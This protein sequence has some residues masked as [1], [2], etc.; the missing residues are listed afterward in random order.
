MPGKWAKRRLRLAKGVVV[1]S[2]IPFLIHAYEYGPDAGLANVPGEVGTCALAGC[3]V[4]TPVNGG[5]GGVMIN[6]PGGQTYVPGTKQ[7]IV[8]TITDSKQKRWGFELTAR[9]AADPS[10][11]AGSFSPTDSHTQLVCASADLSVQLNGFRT[12]PARLPLIYIEHSLGGYSFIQ[13]S[14]ATF[15]FDWNPP[16]TDVGPVT[17]YVS[18][19][20]ANGDLTVNGDHIY[21]AEYTLVTTAAPPTI[22]AGGVRNAASLTPAGLPNSGIAPGSIFVINGNN[23]GLQTALAGTAVQVTATGATLAAPVSAVSATQVTAIMPSDAPLGAGTITVTTNSQTSAPEPVLVT[24]AGFGIYTLNGAGIGPAQATN[25]NGDLITLNNPADPG[26]AITLAGTGLGAIDAA[27][28]T[29]YVGTEPAVVQYAGGSG[30]APGQD[31]VTFVI[32]NDAITGCYVP[33]AVVVDSIASN[34]AS[35]A[36]APAGSVCSDGNGFS[37]FQSGGTVRLA[38]INLTRMTSLAGS[39]VIDSGSAVFTSYTA[40]Q[41]ASSLGPFQTAS[42][43]GCLVFDSVSVIDPTQPQSLAAGSAIAISGPN[44]SRVLT[45]PLAQWA[46]YLDP[47]DYTLTGFGG[48]DVGPFQAQVSMPPPLVWTNAASITSVIRQQGVTVTW[49]G[50]DPNG[51]VYVTGYS[52]AMFTC[53]ASASAGTF[54]VPP[55][56]TNALPESASGALALVGV[57]APVPFTATGLDIGLATASS[58]ISQ[59]EPFQ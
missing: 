37:P 21:T 47:G 43:G 40:S 36:I 11:M 1:C 2:V 13:P 58:G 15:E 31:Q 16:A 45:A 56:V 10:T 19:N 9:L 23:L 44:G 12:C 48:S 35:I 51:F 27:S 50:G 18:A 41:L 5:G 30:A 4:G 38:S 33:V 8:V 25:A 53:T 42:V 59:P 17:I 54:T 29:A 22:N 39:G 34:F 24:A 32:P 20:A 55:L 26:Q 28:V 49:T 52:G 3:H 14:P 46:M 57:S 7:H 6:S